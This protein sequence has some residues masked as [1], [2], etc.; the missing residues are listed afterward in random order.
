MKAVEVRE[1]ALI[2]H[3]SRMVPNYLY[4]FRFLD[5]DM[6][7]VRDL[8]GKVNLHEAVDKETSEHSG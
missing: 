4:K 2:I 7:A 3:S 1:T 5:T 6:V 8:K